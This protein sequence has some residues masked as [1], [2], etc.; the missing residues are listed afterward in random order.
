MD[1]EP[2]LCQLAEDILGSKGY[3]IETAESAAIALEKLSN[4]HF[5]LVLSDIIMPGMNG[6]QLAH[7]IQKRYPTTKIQ[8]TSGFDDHDNIEIIDKFLQD[9]LIHKPYTANTL[10]TQIRSLL[11]A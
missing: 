9:N 4:G 3:Q 5:D 6:Y 8:L 10:L 2:S 7:E 11:D 1:D